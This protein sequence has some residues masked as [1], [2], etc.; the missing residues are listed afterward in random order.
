MAQA[1]FRFYAELNELLPR[2]LRQ[3][4]SVHPFRAP[5]SVKDRIEAKGIPH[6]E[7]DLIL[8]NSTHGSGPAPPAPGCSGRGPTCGACGAGWRTG[9]PIRTSPAGAERV[10]G[11]P[12][13]T[14]VQPVI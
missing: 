5:A 9:W 11:G 7:V 6:T 13:A 4:D 12:P 3:R 10:P 1:I 2:Q 8:V 14:A